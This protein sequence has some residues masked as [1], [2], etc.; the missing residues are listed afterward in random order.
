MPQLELIA[1]QA[2]SLEFH[3]RE[4]LCRPE[5]SMMA[6]EENIAEST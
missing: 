4:G 5:E 2:A 1:V 3:L 6:S